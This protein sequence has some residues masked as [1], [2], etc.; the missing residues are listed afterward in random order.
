MDFSCGIGFNIRGD[1]TNSES[2]T[3]I[4]SSDFEHTYCDATVFDSFSALHP[5]SFRRVLPFQSSDEAVDDQ[6]LIDAEAAHFAE[7]ND[8]TRRNVLEEYFRCGLLQELDAANLRSAVNFF[9]ADFFEMMGLVY[10]NA[11]MFRCALR[12]YRELIQQLETQNPRLRSDEESV[13]A[14][15]GYCLYG[16]GLFEEAIAWSRSCLGPRLMADTICKALIDYEV[17]SVGGGIQ[18]NERAASRTRYTINAPA[19][20]DVSQ[21]VA[22]LKAAMHAFAPFHEVYIDWVNRELPEA[23]PQPDGY[24]FRVEIDAGSLVRHKMNLIFAACGEAD[25]LVERGYVAEAKQL[26]SE[27]ALVEPNA[28]FVW[29]RLRAIE[30]KQR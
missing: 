19:P 6:N 2:Q 11:G 24:P 21:T 16:L 27:V 30:V 20:S 14:S 22:R 17:Q 26:L 4:W 3:P 29:E 12:W 15:V 28:G 25:A 13:Y 1:M 18:R 8:A 23:E 9:E 5:I 10:A 7:R